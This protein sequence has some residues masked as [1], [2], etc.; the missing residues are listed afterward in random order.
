MNFAVFYNEGILHRLKTCSISCT[1]TSWQQ[2]LMEGECLLKVYWKLWRWLST[3]NNS[4]PQGFDVDLNEAKKINTFHRQVA[5]CA[6]SMIT[7]WLNLHDM[8][9]IGLLKCLP[10]VLNKL[11][12][13][14]RKWS[15]V[16][17]IQ[18]NIKLSETNSDFRVKVK[19]LLNFMIAFIQRT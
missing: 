11:L 19:K 8:L 18:N 12:L 5:F 7:W 3:L 2:L 16:Y 17:K 14:W 10:M 15:S 9:L 13:I 6:I 1:R 4:L